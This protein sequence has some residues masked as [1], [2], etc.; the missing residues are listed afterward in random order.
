[1]QFFV[2]KYGGFVL[3]CKMKATRRQKIGDEIQGL[4]QKFKGQMNPNDEKSWFFNIYLLITCNI[5]ALRTFIE[6]NI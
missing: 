6:E 5:K 3:D 2:D 4:K 1:M